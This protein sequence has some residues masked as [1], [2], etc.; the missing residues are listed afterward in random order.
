MKAIIFNR[1]EFVTDV[2]FKPHTVYLCDFGAEIV[3]ISDL[4]IL[5][6]QCY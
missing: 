2:I 6:H 1:M 3:F 5:L 4:G